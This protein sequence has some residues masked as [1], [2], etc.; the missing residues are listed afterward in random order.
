M[1][2][3]VRCIDPVDLVEP[4]VSAAVVELDPGCGGGVVIKNKMPAQVRA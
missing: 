1:E 3:S 4:R 2:A